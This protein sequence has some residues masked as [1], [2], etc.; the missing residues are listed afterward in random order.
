MLKNI[1][2]IV[3]SWEKNYKEK[4]SFLKNIK[5]IEKGIKMGTN[6]WGI[7]LWVS[8]SQK[9]SKMWGKFREKSGGEELKRVTRPIRS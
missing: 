4:N 7:E 3:K 1:Q 5:I 2:T 6:S 8:K 9:S